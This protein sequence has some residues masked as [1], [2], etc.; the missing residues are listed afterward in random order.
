[1]ITAATASLHAAAGDA[2]AAAAVLLEPST[3]GADEVQLHHY[4]LLDP[5]AGD[6]VNM[7]SVY[8]F[9]YMHVFM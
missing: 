8:G 5:I 6:V 1:M 7:S 3:G 2:A 4:S 9:R